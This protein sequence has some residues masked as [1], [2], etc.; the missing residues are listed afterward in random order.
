MPGDF[1]DASKRIRA[2][3]MTAGVCRSAEVNRRQ[4]W[5]TTGRLHNC[6]WMRFAMDVRVLFRSGMATRP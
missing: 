1:A 3:G 2:E 4:L 6:T 5:V